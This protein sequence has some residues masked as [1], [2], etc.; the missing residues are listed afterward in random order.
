MPPPTVKLTRV[1]IYGFFSMTKRTYLIIE[2]VGFAIIF[3]VMAAGAVAMVNAG[4]WLPSFDPGPRGAEPEWVF[5]QFLIGLFWLG[6]LVAVLEGVEALVVL[7]MFAR[8]EALDR[9][10]QADLD[11]TPFAPRPA[12]PTP[13]DVQPAPTAPAPTPSITDTEP[14]HP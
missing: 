1:K 13:Q 14:R 11:T 2:S 7:R 12:G 9:A 10:R 3:A 4:Q 6:L 5:R 8:A